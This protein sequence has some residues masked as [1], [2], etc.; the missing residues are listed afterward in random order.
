MSSYRWA[1]MGDVN[2]FFGLMLDNVAN[3]VIL[4]GVLV[5]V[6][7]YPED[8]V[9]TRMFP[10]TALGVMF[11]DLVYT[12]LAFRL[13][14]K[15]GRDDVTAMPLGLDSPST[16][17]MAFAVLGP[18]F[19]TAKQAGLDD[20]AAGLVGWKVGMATMVLI[21]VFKLVMAFVGGPI[22][23][24]IPAA[25]LLGTLGGIGIALL[26]C[27]QFGELLHE[28]IV[29]FGALGVLLYSLVARIKL[30]FGAPE[31]FTSALV[32]TIL[33]YG[34]AAA[35]LTHGHVDLSGLTFHVGFPLPTL[36]FLEGMPEALGTY[37]PLAIPFALLTVVGGINV[38]ESARLAGDDYDTREILLTEAFATLL[39]GVCGG[40]AQSTPYIGQP[41]YKAMGGRAAYTLATGLFIGL[42]GILGY[43][44][45]M[46][47]V[48]PKAALVP[49]FLFVAVDIVEQSFHAV[50]RR[51]AMA[52]AF[53][54]FPNIAQLILIIVSQANGKLLEAPSDP[55]GVIAATKLPPDFVAS[56]GVFIM[57][58]HGFILTGMLWGAA[59]A[60][61]VD[62]QAG[63]ATATWLVCAAM[64][65]CGLIHSVDKDGGVYLPWSAPNDLPLQWALG[66][67]LM[68]VTV[69][70][71]SHSREFSEAPAEG[72]A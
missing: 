46:A 49:I 52:V 14:A 30:P 13:A 15:T 39:A 60:F 53:A 34:L 68:A 36:G 48:L 18:A 11:G 33:Y 3:L 28:P 24:A 58:A 26:G 29:G 9:Y 17:G 57:L 27:L 19:V 56:V 32:G 41:A 70:A 23:R 2:A 59:I 37:M 65:T 43:I 72:H 45:L 16:I 63:K 71:L 61:T 38:T 10:G 67:V 5:F 22:Q 64:T 69:Y 12:W 55:A 7:G 51:H 47:Q 4:S 66:Y 20:A 35:G 40:V 31:V 54:M 8:I 21:G 6:F 50:P 1:R 44:P 62:R 25:G 42:G